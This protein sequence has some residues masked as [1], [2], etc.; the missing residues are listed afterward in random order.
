MSPKLTNEQIAAERKLLEG[1]VEVQRVGGCDVSDLLVAFDQLHLGS[2]VPCVDC[3]RMVGEEPADD[4]EFT[5]HCWSL[6]RD[7]NKWREMVDT[8]RAE[9]TRGGASHMTVLSEVNTF[10]CLCGEMC[11]KVTTGK[12]RGRPSVF[13]CSCGH[14]TVVAPTRLGIAET[15]PNEVVD[16]KVESIK[17]LRSLYDIELA[18]G[19]QGNLSLIFDC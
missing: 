19:N 11:A 8:R 1:F 12:D 15:R 16:R 2:D 10:N 13:N 17:M 5:C 6:E 4:V 9:G 7:L 14:I 3:D 18:K